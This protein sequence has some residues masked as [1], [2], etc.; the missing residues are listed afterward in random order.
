MDKGLIDNKFKVLY[1]MLGIFIVIYY[2]LVWETTLA[3][4][5]NAIF[6]SAFVGL[7]YV[8][9]LTLEKR[10][11]ACKESQQDKEKL[12]LM[13]NEMK[14]LFDHNNSYLWSIDLEERIFLPSTGIEEILG[15]SKEEFRRNYELW[16]ERVLPEDRSLAEEYYERLKR[17]EP[18]NKSFRVRNKAG[19]IRWIDAWGTPLKKNGRVTHLTGV[20]YDITER[21]QLEKE[22]KYNA[23][24]DYL[25]GLPNRRL[26]NHFVEREIEQNKDSSKRFAI[27]YL[28]LD[29]FKH[30]NDHYGHSKGDSLLIQAAQRLR[31]LVD[32]HSIVSRQGGDEFIIITPYHTYDALMVLVRKIIDAFELPFQLDGNQHL[33]TSV[34]ISIYPKDGQTVDSLIGQADRA[35]YQAKNRGKSNYQ[36]ADPVSHETEVRKQKIEYDLY[37]AIQKNELY[38]L[39]QP[40]IILKTG[41][42]YGVEALLR[43]AHPEMG[44]ISPGEFIPLAEAKG[45]IHDMGIWVL[46]EVVRQSKKW[47][48]EGIHLTFAV[49]VSNQQFENPCFLDKVKEIIEKN[50]FDPTRLSFE[51]TESFMQNAVST[52]AIHELNDMGIDIA[53]DDFGT[54]YSSLSVLSSIPVNEIKIDRSFVQQLADKQMNGQIVSTIIKMSRALNCRT[55]AE[56]IE[57]EEEADKLRALGCELG[58]GYL[59]SRPIQPD[60]VTKLIFRLRSERS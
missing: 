50:Q 12:D 6:L 39:Y 32:E 59:Y 28:D 44:T 3:I 34:G 27:L 7:V 22:L 37:K 2:S 36:F 55:V 25:T 35:M 17:G 48:A 38:I 57:T 31:S 53:I 49:N 47:D 14:A 9:I 13:E 26:L 20:A 41:E 8:L 1:V 21:K 24:H 46:D 18:S 45:V 11:R 56:G 33:T 4:L 58:Q 23:T 43:W 16:L 29:N 15:Y 19:E 54:G 10:E 60:D 51:I 30:M 40:K 42:L 52:K 5:L